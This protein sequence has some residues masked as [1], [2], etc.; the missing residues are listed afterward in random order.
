M[1]QDWIGGVRNFVHSQEIVVLPGNWIARLRANSIGG[2]DFGQ[3]CFC[4]WVYNMDTFWSKDVKQSFLIVCGRHGFSDSERNW[5]H[6][7]TEKKKLSILRVVQFWRVYWVENPLYPLR[8]PPPPSPL[9]I[10]N[11]KPFDIKNIKQTA[12]INMLKTC[13][14]YIWCFVC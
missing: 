9:F 1:P 3:N 14:L 12:V 13:I 5:K 6:S 10:H 8:F 7:T 11:R 2:S 4:L